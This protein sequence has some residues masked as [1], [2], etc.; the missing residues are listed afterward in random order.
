M[1][2]FSRLLP[3]HNSFRR[4]DVFGSSQRHLSTKIPLSQ[5]IVTPYPPLSEPLSNLPPVQYAKPS[6]SPRETQITT[7]PNG[8]RVA[9]ESRFGQFCTVGGTHFRH[10]RVILINSLNNNVIFFCSTML[11]LS[12]TRDRDTKWPFPAAFHIFL[13]SLLSM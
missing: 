8:L 4:R 3:L 12:S 1:L 10:A 5:Q 13:R 9:S 6:L 7:L 11:Q 2:V